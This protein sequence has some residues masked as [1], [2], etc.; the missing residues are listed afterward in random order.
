[1]KKIFLATTA[2]TALSVAG[3][4]NAAEWSA[5]IGGYM[6]I[7]VAFD[8]TDDVDGIG[9]L[10]DGEIHAKAKMVADN[11]LTFDGR[12][13]LE[14][15]TDGDDVSCTSTSGQFVNS[16]D[17]DLDTLLNTPTGPGDIN[18]DGSYIDTVGYGSAL[19]SASCKGA[20]GDQID[21]NWVR[22]SGSFGAIKIG[23][24]DSA[25]NAYANGVIYAPSA[26]IGYYDG[27]GYVNPVQPGI[28]GGGDYIGIHYD[29][30]DFS[31]FRFGATYQPNRSS[32][33]AGDTNGPVYNV[34]SDG[35]NFW[36]VGAV[37]SG[38]F[39][40]FGVGISGG[41]ADSDGS[42]METWHVGG[43]VSSSGFTLAV[44]YEDNG[45]SSD[46]T[47]LAIGASYAT[48]PWTI[49]G[50][51]AQQDTPSADPQVI[52]AWVTYAVAPGVKATVGFE[53]GDEDNGDDEVLG[54][55]AYLNLGF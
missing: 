24:D 3:A 34:D 28:S 51:W 8:G 26:L 53:Y 31:G 39:N 15:F 36:A 42:D 7:G 2:I 41:Y 52:S 47:D 38:D 4:A 1:M 22:V 40:G 32:D 50:G 33:G 46:N 55:M 49:A 25:K 14:A 54:G 23:G 29:S 13:E 10:R 5:G 30:P 9:I 44:H 16:A 48:G 35:D 27:F 12:V 43:N 17:T 21:E 6:Q 11:G 18:S 20:N 19:T 37:Y 45:G